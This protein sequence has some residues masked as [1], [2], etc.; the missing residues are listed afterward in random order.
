M[1]EIRKKY[2]DRE[3]KL[4]ELLFEFHNLPFDDQIINLEYYCT[5]FGLYTSEKDASDLGKFPTPSLSEIQESQADSILSF[6]EV[7]NY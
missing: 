5:E 4:K 7:L 3:K 6:R 2:L 1:P